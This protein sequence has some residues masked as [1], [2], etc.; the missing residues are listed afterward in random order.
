VRVGVV[1]VLEG[2][3]LRD[4]LTV[5]LG[6]VVVLDGL[7]V[8]VRVGVV[9]VLEGVVLRDGLTVLLGDVVVL[10]GLDVRVRVGAVVVREGAVY[11]PDDELPCVAAELRLGDELRGVV[12]LLLVSPVVDIVPLPCEGD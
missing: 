8:R 1:R 6:D 10:D 3:V 9:R 7:D 12:V 5:L 11:V 2:V 4:G